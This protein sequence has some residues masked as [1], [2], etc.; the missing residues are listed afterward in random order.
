LKIVQF[1]VLSP[2]NVAGTPVNSIAHIKA[3]RIAL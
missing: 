3:G 1:L 2:L